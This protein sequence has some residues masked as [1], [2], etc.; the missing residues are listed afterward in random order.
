MMKLVL[1][2]VILFLTE[3]FVFS[4]T[5]NN[6]SETEYVNPSSSAKPEVTASAP[7][8]GADEPIKPHDPEPSLSAAPSV[9]MTTDIIT[10]SYQT[11]L[12]QTAM[13]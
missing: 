13:S 12:Y 4:E 8:L 7:A 1:C 9:S 6:V 3:Q 2:L 5:L 11:L 10:D